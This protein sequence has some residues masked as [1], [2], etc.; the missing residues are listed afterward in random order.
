[1]SR[2]EVLEPPGRSLPPLPERVR[3]AVVI[4]ALDAADLLPG[5]LERVL[6]GLRP[7]DEVVVAAGDDESA[8][9]VREVDDPRV[10]IVDN[11]RTATP[12]ALNLAIAA[13][14]APVVVR[15]DTASRVPPGYVD[16][17]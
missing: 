7:D 17:V 14:S 1:M 2:G 10:R 15:V 11:P 9:A 6:A 3:R 16:R 4:P 13:T 5:C 8:A 12:T